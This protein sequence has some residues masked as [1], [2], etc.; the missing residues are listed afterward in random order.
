MRRHFNII[1][2]S[3]NTIISFFILRK[4][5]TM[6]VE[7]VSIPVTVGLGQECFFPFPICLKVI[8]IND[9]DSFLKIAREKSPS[10]INNWFYLSLTS[11]HQYH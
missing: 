8:S 5:F 4:M 10:H 7:P 3:S 1:P 2:S 11:H 6:L 9:G